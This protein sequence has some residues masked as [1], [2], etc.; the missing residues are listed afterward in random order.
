MI[1]IFDS[2]EELSRAAAELFIS[3]SNEA[4]AKTE[5][6]LVALS[7][8]STP[9]RVFEILS[10]TS[11][12]E[13]VDWSK[14]F[15]FWGDER[16][17]PFED[18][19]SNA[20]M[21]YKAL[22][23]HVTIPQEQIFRIKGEL[24]PQEA[25]SQYNELL[26]TFFEG[27]EKTFDLVYLGMGPDGHTASLFPY[28]T[29]LDERIALAKEVYLEELK[30]FRVSITQDTINRAEKIAFLITGENKADVLNEV[31]FGE[32]N[33]KQ[34]P[35]QLIHPSNGELIWY[36]DRAASKVIANKI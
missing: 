31:M 19:E 10:Q 36:L 7:G 9:K 34:F 32:K 14:V 18:A 22:L 16:C 17:V 35:S 2:S 27:N 6:F 20:G 23:N 5:R 1:K 30:K 15:I 11:F 26:T 3:A 8:G 29:I 21:T 25:A 33:T 13:R 28:T 4:I 24:S 12:Q